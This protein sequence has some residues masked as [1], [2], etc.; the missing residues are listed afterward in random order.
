MW[1]MEHAEVVD[2]RILKPDAFTV[3][4]SKWTVEHMILNLSRKKV[5]L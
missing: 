2:A 1:R 5:E 4:D 3:D